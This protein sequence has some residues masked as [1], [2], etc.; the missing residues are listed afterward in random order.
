MAGERLILT[1]GYGGWPQMSA[2]D[3]S[4][5]QAGREFNGYAC[6]SDVWESFDGVV[7]TKLADTTA[8][9]P[10]AWF[11]AAVFSHPDE[12]RIDVSLSSGFEVPSIIHFT[13]IFTPRAESLTQTNP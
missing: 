5:A 7:W 3:S 8:M 2:Y 11:G 10:R 6:L 4:A 9:G 13:A 1:A 12:P